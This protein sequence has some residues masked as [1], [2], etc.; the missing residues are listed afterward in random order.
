VYDKI[1]IQKEKLQIMYL[2]LKFKYLDWP[3]LEPHMVSF[4]W[5]YDPRCCD[6]RPSDPVDG[7][8]YGVQWSHCRP[9][10]GGHSFI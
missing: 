4:H 1:I 6:A 9:T 8:P 7:Q 10:Y 2:F 5:W 3:R